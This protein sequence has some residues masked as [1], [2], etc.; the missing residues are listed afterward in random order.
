LAKTWLQDFRNGL[1][2]TMTPDSR[3]R[4]GGGCPGQPAAVGMSAHLP[5][6]PELDLAELWLEIADLM[7]RQFEHWSRQADDEPHPALRRELEGIAADAMVIANSAR[8]DAD[9]ILWDYGDGGGL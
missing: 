5:T 1:P 4:A 8:A 6:D 9:D 3:E 2:I 7:E